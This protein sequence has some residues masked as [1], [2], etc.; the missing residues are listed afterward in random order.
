MFHRIG[1][2]EYAKACGLWHMDLILINSGL[3]Y[4]ERLINPQLLDGLIGAFW[5]GNKWYVGPFGLT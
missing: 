2:H 5:Y 3:N 4:L 1:L